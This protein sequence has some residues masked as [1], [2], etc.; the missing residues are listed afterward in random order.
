M[1]RP[2]SKRCRRRTDTTAGGTSA[3]SAPL[4]VKALDLIS[5]YRTV[6]RRTTS[7]C[8]PLTVDDHVVQSMPDAS[9]AKWHL[10]HTTWFFETF[11]LGLTGKWTTVFNSYYDAIGARVARERRGALSRPTLDEV[12]AYR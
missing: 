2:R 1:F 4:R 6:R 9:P 10:G 7:A 5:R 11:A 3:A 12:H 8:A